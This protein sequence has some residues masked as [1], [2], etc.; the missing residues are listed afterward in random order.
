MHEDC[1]LLDGI[2]E[3]SHHL[4]VLVLLVRMKLWV[5]DISRTSDLGV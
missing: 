1:D 3:T 2:V 5:N 4:V